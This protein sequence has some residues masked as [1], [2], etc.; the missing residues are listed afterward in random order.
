MAIGAVAFNTRQMWLP[1]LEAAHIASALPSWAYS[2]KPPSLGLNLLDSNGQLQIRWN[3]AAPAM[4]N[5]TGA[6]LDIVDGSALPHSVTL[7]QAHLQSGFFTYARESGEVDVAITVERPGGAP[8]KEAT[9]F[10]GKPPAAASAAGDDTENRQQRDDSAVERARL[11][12][13]L[14]AET[15]R[16]KK[17]ERSLAE[18]RGQ[19]KGQQRKRLETQDTG[20]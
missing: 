3:A 13:E 8:L 17:L 16:S 18:A 1:R 5:A 2:A 10:W 19:M 7:D 20:R 14:K 12:A 4:A 11:E 9:S 15:E 6:V